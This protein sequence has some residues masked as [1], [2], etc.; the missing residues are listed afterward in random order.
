M[1]PVQVAPKSDGGG[2]QPLEVC[3]SNQYGWCPLRSSGWG[4]ALGCKGCVTMRLGLNLA[5]AIGPKPTISQ[6]AESPS[7]EGY[8]DISSSLGCSA[9]A[10]NSASARQQLDQSG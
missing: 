8:F 6:M 5:I 10:A 2:G 9:A 1:K 7:V 4:E 3:R